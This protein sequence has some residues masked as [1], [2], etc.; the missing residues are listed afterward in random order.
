MLYTVGKGCFFLFFFTFRYLFL[1]M[2]TMRR[3]QL[4]L[5]EYVQWI[6]GTKKQETRE[7]R[8]KNAVE[9]IGTGKKT[10]IVRMAR[11]RCDGEHQAD[12]HSL[13]WTSL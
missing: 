1:S 7:N 3:T 2:R 12:N 8:M 9:Q 5:K 11:A 6:E 13:F 10:L 4:F